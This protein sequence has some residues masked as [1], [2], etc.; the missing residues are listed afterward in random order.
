MTRYLRL[1]EPRGAVP[2]L[3]GVRGIAIFMV[4]LFHAAE[5]FRTAGSPL[6]P[7]FGL[8]LSA[9]L[10][11]GWAGVNL[12][13]VL[14][15]FLI[16]RQLI[17][18]SHDLGSMGGI[19]RYLAKRWLRIV[20]LYLTVL[21]AAVLELTPG[22]VVSAEHLRFRVGYHLLFLQDYLPS[23]IL[24]P[25]WSLGVEEKFYLIMPVLLLVLLALKIPRRQVTLLIGLACL[26]LL[27]RVIK[28]IG[29]DGPV[30]TFD[31]SM[32]WRS[33][34]HMNLDALMAGVL[35]SWLV[36][37]RDDFPLLRSADF[38]RALRVVGGIG[39]G[40]VAAVT[41]L[42]ARPPWFDRVPQEPLIALSMGLWILGVAL[43]PHGRQLVLESR[44]LAR[45]GRLA[46]A[47][48]LSHILIQWW[49]LDGRV[50]AGENAGAAFLRFFPQ[51]LVFS[52]I[53]ALVLHLAIE[54]P[55]LL[56]KARIDTPSRT[57]ASGFG[58]LS[59]SSP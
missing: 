30:S 31:F 35:A 11:V 45:A 39:F 16:T 32:G 5:P 34:F 2:A 59:S 8:D 43:E 48:Y 23:D 22:H 25:F 6:L 46:Y 26:P 4:V 38:A 36:H 55:F 53:A 47:W 40:L 54:K 17:R 18:H 50:P 49:L 56:L 14:S 44:W 24:G 58:Q 57:P 1:V 33:P 10:Q 51:F 20:P 13:F 21:F 12:F 29:V 37:R 42:S 15:G 52:M 3:D 9:P 7:V 27:F 41:L 28:E 19:G